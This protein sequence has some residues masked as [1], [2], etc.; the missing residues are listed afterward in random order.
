MKVNVSIFRFVLYATTR[1]AVGAVLVG[2]LTFTPSVTAQL[3][4]Y[5]I[6][7]ANAV[8]DA[9]ITPTAVS[10]ITANAA[11]DLTQTG[12]TAFASDGTFAA[13]GWGTSGVADTGKY[14]EFTVEPTAGNQI[15][16]SSLVGSVFRGSLGGADHGAESWELRSSVDGFAASVGS[17]ISLVGSPSG[18]QGQ[19]SIALGSLGTTTGPTTFRIYGYNDTGTGRSGGLANSGLL[20]GTPSNLILD[21]TVSAVPEPELTAG[22]IALGLLGF[23]IARKRISLR[24]GRAA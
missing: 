10:G 19:F 1:A 13:T 4:T 21:G 22:V 7:T 18:G 11:L 6:S 14:F 24:S 9:S 2:A 17:P 8:N 12:V 5:D 16:F 20:P 15:T 3:L 23:A